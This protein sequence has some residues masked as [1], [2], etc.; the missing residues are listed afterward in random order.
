MSIPVLLYH[1]IGERADPRFARWVV[2]PERFA[3]QMELLAAEGYHALTATEAA[4]ALRGEIASPERVVAITFDDGFA[5]V[6]AVAWP[7]LRRHGLTAT[8]YV[9]TGYVGATSRWLKDEGEGG[10]VMLGWDQVADLARNG[11]EIGAHTESH[12]A[13]DTTSPARAAREIVRSRDALAAVVGPVASF[14]YPFGYHRR[15]VRRQVRQAGFTHAYTVGDGIASAADDRFA[16]TRAIVARDTTIEHFAQIVEAR[17]GSVGRRPLRRVA[18][19]AARRA[20]A[21][22]LV[23]RLRGTVAAR[24]VG[25]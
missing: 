16:I 24:P 4:D 17:T 7:E 12:V 1:G 22:P 2:R 13:L 9:A 3:E 8:V 15:S 14:A 6:H 10:R 11:I 21:Q 5:D 20:G 23:D 18:W 25:G 19:R